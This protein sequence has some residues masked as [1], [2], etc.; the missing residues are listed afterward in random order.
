MRAERDRAGSRNFNRRPSVWK[1]SNAG[2]IAGACLIDA[3]RKQGER[4]HAKQDA[5]RDIDDDRAD[6]LGV[7]RPS[8]AGARPN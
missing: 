2:V 8:D 5:Y 3:T 4:T 7:R 6:R 1:I